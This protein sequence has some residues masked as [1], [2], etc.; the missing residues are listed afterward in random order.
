MDTAN[1]TTDQ[2]VGG[3][4][5]SERTKKT[6]VRMGVRRGRV[7]LGWGAGPFCNGFCNGLS[8][9]LAVAG[10]GGLTWGVSDWNQMVASPWVRPVL[11]GIG[12]TE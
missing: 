10:C 11:A 12:V 6:Q 9:H 1:E 8:R 3:S 5:P 7:P 2:K 4:S